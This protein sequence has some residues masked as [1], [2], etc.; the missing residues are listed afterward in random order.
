MR[1]MLETAYLKYRFG[2]FPL[3]LS[4]PLYPLPYLLLLPSTPSF[5]N[6]SL[7]RCWS[8]QHKHCTNEGRGNK[9]SSYCWII[10]TKIIVSSLPAWNVNFHPRHVLFKK[11]KRKKKKHSA[12]VWLLFPLSGLRWRARNWNWEDMKLAHRHAHRRHKGDW[13]SSD[14]RTASPICSRDGRDAASRG[15]TFPALQR[16]AR[17]PE[18]PEG[19]CGGTSH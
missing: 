5:W 10:W 9:E 6:C 1:S 11:K 15:I 14:F 18:E 17:D 13:E 12:V 2:F 4:F 3:T 16:M 8:T 19:V 7:Q